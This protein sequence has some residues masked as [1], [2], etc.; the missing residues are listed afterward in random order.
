MNPGLFDCQ[1]V[2]I[3]D[4]S[5]VLNLCPTGCGYCQEPDLCT[6]C[7]FNYTLGKQLYFD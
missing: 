7:A 3:K 4:I 6:T 1:Y 5:I 2:I